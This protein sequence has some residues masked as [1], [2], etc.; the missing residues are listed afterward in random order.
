M[1]CSADGTRYIAKCPRARTL[2]LAL[3]AV[4]QTAAGDVTGNLLITKRL[5]RKRVE[6]QILKL[7]YQLVTGSSETGSQPAAAVGRAAAGSF[8]R[9]GLNTRLDAR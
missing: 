2:I 9:I 6:R 1:A 4:S 3:V 5:T 7:S 8:G